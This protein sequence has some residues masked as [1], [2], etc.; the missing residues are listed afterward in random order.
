MGYA[1]DLQGDQLLLI[2]SHLASFRCPAALQKRGLSSRAVLQEAAE[3]LRAGPRVQGVAAP[4][5]EQ[6]RLAG[7]HTGR[8]NGGNSRTAAPAHSLPSRPGPVAQ[9]STGMRD[10]LQLSWPQLFSLQ[11]PGNLLQPLHARLQPEHLTAATATR[12]NSSLAAGWDALRRRLGGTARPGVGE[13]TP[14]PL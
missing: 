8:P 11:R 13:P 12:Q 10:R 3:V 4:C 1:E 9:D 7:A 2:F 14:P 5:A 6:G